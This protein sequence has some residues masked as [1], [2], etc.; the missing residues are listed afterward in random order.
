MICYGNEI[1]LLFLLSGVFFF[2]LEP[3]KDRASRMVGQSTDSHTTEPT[4]LLQLSNVLP[5]LRLR[6]SLREPLLHGEE[7][8]FLQEIVAS[9]NLANFHLLQR[10][11]QA[12]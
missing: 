3:L 6:V 8:F 5:F 2:T 10:A 11:L 7:L 9:P 4:S 12:T 1:V